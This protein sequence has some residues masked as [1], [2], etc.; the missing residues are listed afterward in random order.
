MDIISAMEAQKELI[1]QAFCGFAQAFMCE[2]HFNEHCAHALSDY[3][4]PLSYWKT[5]LR[6]INHDPQTNKQCNTTDSKLNI[7]L[8]FTPNG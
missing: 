3:S 2:E 1:G 4:H 8:N 6:R 7:G 5:K